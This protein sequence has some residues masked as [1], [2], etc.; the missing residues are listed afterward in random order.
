MAEYSGMAAGLV[1]RRRSS[2]A[3]DRVICDWSLHAIRTEDAKAG[4]KLVL[5][6]FMLTATRGFTRVDGDKDCAVCMKPGTQ[7]CIDGCTAVFARKNE[8]IAACH[9][10]CF[11]FVNGDVRY[12]SNLPL[13]TICDVLQMPAPQAVQDATLARKQEVLFDR[14]AGMRTMEDITA[15]A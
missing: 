12:A 13:G 14:L 2:N 10:D 8:H 6:S 7:V 3:S 9:H 1:S 5:S 15:L 11:E 4:D